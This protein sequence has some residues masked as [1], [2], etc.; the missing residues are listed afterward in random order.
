VCQFVFVA[1]V[2]NKVRRTKKQRPGANNKT[3]GRQKH[4]LGQ[5]P[6]GVSARFPGQSRA[7]AHLGI[8]T[9]LDMQRLFSLT[10]YHISIQNAILHG[11][12][13]LTYDPR[14]LHSEVGPRH[15][16]ISR[17]APKQT[18]PLATNLTPL[19]VH[20]YMCRSVPRH[21]KFVGFQI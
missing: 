19:K 8:G 13:V 1:R 20:T 12:A 7:T 10:E 18:T 5:P 4:N 3:S 21:L 11:N 16:M 9:R 2:P 6:T 17:P 14:E 15:F